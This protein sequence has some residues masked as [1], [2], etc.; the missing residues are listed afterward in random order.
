MQTFVYIIMVVLNMGYFTISKTNGIG[1]GNRMLFLIS[2]RV[3]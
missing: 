2:D 1:S 3:R